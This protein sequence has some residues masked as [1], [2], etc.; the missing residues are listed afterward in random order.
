MDRSEGQIEAARDYENEFP[1]HGP[2][3]LCGDLAEL[4]RLTTERFGAALCLGNVL[5]H[6][7]DE[8]LETV[9]QGL[10]TRLLPDGRLILQL[11]NYERIF[12]QGIRHLPLNFRDAPRAPAEGAGADEGEPAPEGEPGEEIVFLRLVRPDGER[13]VR[14][15]PSTL[16][17]R[18]GSDPPVTLESSREVRLRAWRRPEVEA[19]LEAAG[20][21]VGATYGDMT[22]GPF[23]PEGSMDLVVVAVRRP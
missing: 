15:Y 13:H 7:E 18:P 23:A 6:L 9:L 14:F 2:R 12:A 10:A 8:A 20:F 16:A 19:A 3:F 11:I 1:P 21:G 4:E 5:P 22:G 17:L